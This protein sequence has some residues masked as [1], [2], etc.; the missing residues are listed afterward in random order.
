[1]YVYMHQASRMYTIIALLL[2]MIATGAAAAAGVGGGYSRLGGIT[3]YR[4]AIKE[5]VLL[6]LQLPQLF[7]K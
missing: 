3:A 6:P 4:S 7:Q 1:M 5:L 2:S